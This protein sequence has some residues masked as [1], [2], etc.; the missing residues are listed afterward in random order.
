M[1]EK[2]TASVTV[3]S[4]EVTLNL[5]DTA[6]ECACA[7]GVPGVRPPEGFPLPGVPHRASP[8]SSLAR[9]LA[10]S[11]LLEAAQGRWLRDP[12]GQA[13][14]VSGE[15]GGGGELRGHPPSSVLRAHSS[16]LSCGSRKQW[17]A[18]GPPMVPGLLRCL[19]WSLQTLWAAD[20]S[21]LVLGL[22]GLCVWVLWF[23]DAPG[24][25]SACGSRA[26]WPALCSLRFWGSVDASSVSAAPRI[27]RLA[28]G[29]G[30]VWLQLFLCFP[31]SLG[32]NQTV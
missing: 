7:P 8:A 17:A 19:L 27:P 15:C 23:W 1:F 3:G 5:Y 16:F 20:L 4:K 18:L 11:S 6:G 9:V 25:K 14:Y 12:R 32:Q 10:G 22:P 13:L 30:I 2:Y 26:L 31:S 24:C 28:V 21:P 29:S